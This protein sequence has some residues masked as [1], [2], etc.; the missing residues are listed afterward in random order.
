MLFLY[1]LTFKQNILF[2]YLIPQTIKMNC[3]AE[4]VTNNAVSSLALTKSYF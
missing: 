1:V 4:I 2:L 3:N